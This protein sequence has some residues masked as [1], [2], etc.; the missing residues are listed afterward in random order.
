LTASEEEKGLEN[1]VLITSKLVSGQAYDLENKIT[2]EIAWALADATSFN[3]G[4][5]GGFLTSYI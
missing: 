2:T 1:L 5:A 4:K 3:S